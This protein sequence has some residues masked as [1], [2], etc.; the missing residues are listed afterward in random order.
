[1]LTCDD[2]VEISKKPIAR[3]NG[4][5]PYFTM[6]PL[7][8]PF[9]IL[10]ISNQRDVVLDPFCGRGTT[11]FAARLKG[12]VS[13]GIDSNPLAVA[14]SQSKIVNVSVE[15]VLKELNAILESNISFELP[16]GEFWDYAYHKETLKEICKIRQSLLD[17]CGSKER[18][19]LR[20]IMLGALH[21]PLAKNLEN[22][23]YFSNQMP[24]TY[25]S[26]PNYS[27]KYWKKNGLKPPKVSVFKV[28]KRRTIRY[29]S[30]TLDFFDEDSKVNQG[31]SRDITS[32]KDMKKVSFIITSPPYYGLNSYITDQWLRNW[33]LGGPDSL[34][35][36]LNK[37]IDHSSPE[38]FAFSLARVWD[39]CAEI[40]NDGAFLYVRFGGIPSR[41]ADPSKILTRSFELSKAP[42]N[43][44]KTTTAGT[45]EQGRRQSVQMNSKSNQAREELDMELRLG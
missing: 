36:K 5:C 30:N 26:K 7:D 40:A 43:I 23:S 20:A 9:N 10:S 11:L 17:Y 19:M 3:L 44:I 2:I 34:D 1:M 28:V 12:L 6:F 16:S 32:Y 18:I 35:Y 41:K 15:E 22:T 21:G 33:F 8:F 45:A 42:W 27:I 14:I 31:D 4:I 37:Q 39:N 25:A 24:R 38:N 13:Y 29:L